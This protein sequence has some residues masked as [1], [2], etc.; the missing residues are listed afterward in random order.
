MFLLFSMV[1]EDDTCA[2]MALAA[3]GLHYAGKIDPSIFSSF[4]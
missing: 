1:C 2:L 4:V 3:L